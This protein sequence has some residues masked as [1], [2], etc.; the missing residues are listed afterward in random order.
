MPRR[1]S[2]TKKYI[3][4]IGDNVILTLSTRSGSIYG[5]VVDRIRSMDRPYRVEYTNPVTHQLKLS[6]FSALDLKPVDQASASLIQD[7][8]PL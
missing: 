5:R 2:Q 4:R 1:Q 7:P 3:P 8:Q 6:W